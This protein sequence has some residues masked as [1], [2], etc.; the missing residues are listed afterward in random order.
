MSVETRRRDDEL[1][2]YHRQIKGSYGVPTDANISQRSHVFKSMLF[3]GIARYQN[4][5]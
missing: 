5:V 4:I 3:C 2:K 1:E